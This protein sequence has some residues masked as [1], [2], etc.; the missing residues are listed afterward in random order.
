MWVEFY[1]QQGRP[2]ARRHRATN[3]LDTHIVDSTTL[4]LPTQHPSLRTQTIAHQTRSVPKLTN[5]WTNKTRVL[6]THRS[7]WAFAADLRAQSGGRG[8]CRRWAPAAHCPCTMLCDVSER[9]LTHNG[10]RYILENICDVLSKNASSSADTRLI[11]WL[12]IILFKKN[13]N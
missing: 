5:R 3:D 8:A 13:H 2:P 11:G 9:W 6:A 12:Y 7:D 10:L 4:A 1:H